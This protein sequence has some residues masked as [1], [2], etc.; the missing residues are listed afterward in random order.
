MVSGQSCGT[1]S[2]AQSSGGC[3]LFWTSSEPGGCELDASTPMVEINLSRCL[4][5]LELS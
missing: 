1:V 2:T 3:C 4:V 5:S